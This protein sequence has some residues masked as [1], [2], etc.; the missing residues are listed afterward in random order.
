LTELDGFEKNEGIIVIAATNM[1]DA[2]DAA[3]T[4]PGRFDKQVVVPIPDV[5]GRKEILDLYLSK[6]QVSTDVDSQR[7]A[8]ATPGFT[9]ADLNQLVN[10]AA[11][12]AVVQGKNQVTLSVI[13]ET[14]DDIWMGRM[15][16][17]AVVDEAT[18][19]M[20]AYHEGGHALVSLCVEGSDPIHKATIIQRGHALGM[21]SHLPEGDQ[22]SRSRK[23]MMAQLAVCMAGRAAEEL[24]YGEYEVTSGASSD[25]QTATSLAYSMVT[26]WGMSDKVGFIHLSNDRKISPEQRQLIDSEVKRLLDERYKFAKQLLIDNRK[27]L[28][29]IAKLLLEKETV[30]GEELKTLVGR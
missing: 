9:G 16:R 2:L 3:L 27:D 17:S 5:K 10:L 8:R 26:K 18:R 15:R 21:V 19:S 7:I 11:I 30:N 6:V 12:K 25:F 14:R 4:R 29:A 1:P 23:Q 22:L 24:V 20:T 28:D 13:E